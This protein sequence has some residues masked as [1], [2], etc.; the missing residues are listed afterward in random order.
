MVSSASQTRVR[1]RRLPLFLQILRQVRF[2]LL[3]RALL[4]V[5]DSKLCA[6]GGALPGLVQNAALPSSSPVSAPAFSSPSSTSSTSA[7][8]VGVL[9]AVPAT[10]RSHP[11]HQPAGRTRRSPSSA[12]HLQLPGRISR[13]P[14]AIS[15]QQQQQLL[16]P[17]RTSRSP[18][19]LSCPQP[20]PQLAGRTLRPP[21]P[22]LSSPQLQ[23]VGR[24]FSSPLPL[25]PHPLLGRA[26][27]PLLPPHL[28]EF[29][30]TPRVMSVAP[31][32]RCYRKT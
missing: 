10:R 29:R 9:F 4:Q 13:S 30:G 7:P 25:R 2:S 27:Q 23:F 20:Q 24:T 5:P 21:R 31:E 6:T 26:P 18:A 15:T 32:K 11:L 16:L 12:L 17:G 8:L 28:G 19:A 1:T 22:A 14:P 3:L